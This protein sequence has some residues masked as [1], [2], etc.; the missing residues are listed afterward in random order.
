[1]IYKKIFKIIF[2]NI[3]IFLIAFTFFINQVFATATATPA[4]GGSAISADTTGGSYT[5]LNGPIISEGATGD[6]GTGT[7]ILNVPSGFV[8][9][10][11]STAPNVLVTR[12]AGSGNNNRNING[13]ASGS[14]IAVT[15]TSNTLAITITSKTSSGVRNS[16]T[17]QNVRAR[18]SAGTPLA[19]GNIIKSGTSSIS[20]VTGSTNFGT[21]TEVVGVKTQLVYTTQPSSSAETNSDFSTKPVIAVRDQ[22]GNTA[23]SDNS[24]TISLS[25]VLS[26][27][28]CG[29]AAGSGTI[30]ST[31]VSGVSVVSGIVAYTAMK[32]S[33]GESIKICA[34]SSGL[35]SAL[36]NAVSVSN[37]APV[38]SLI[39]PTSR[40]AGSGA[41]TL[42]LNGSGFVSDSSVLW[43][44][45]SRAT[46]FVSS[47][48]LTAAITAA[49]VA[50]VGT[51]SVSVSNPAPGGGVSGSQTFT[52]SVG[53]T[54]QL[55]LNNISSIIAGDRASYVVNR[56]DQ[57]GNLV[58]SGNETFYLYSSATGGLSAFYDTASA[59]NIITSITIPNG[60]SS[61][62]FWYYDQVVGTS[63]ISISDNSTAPDG[64]AGIDDATDQISI[65]AATANQFNLNDPGSITAGARAAY[66]ITRKDQFGNLVSSGN[67][68]AY[69]YSDAVGQNEKFYDSATNG[70]IITSVIIPDGSSS[71]NFWYYDELVGSPTITASDN[72]SAPDGATGIDDATD[73]ISITATLVSQFSLNDVSS[74][75]AGT[76]AA[77]TITRKDQ[78]GNLTTS[79]NT[80][81]YLYTNSTGTSAIFYDAASA[82]NAITSIQIADG[83]S[84]ANF[85]Y[86]DDSIGAWTI[87]ASDNATAPDGAIGIVDATDQ[88]A[89]NAAPIVATRF[90]IVVQSSATAG[91]TV[92]VTIRAEDSSGN[93]DTSYSG[94]VTLVTSG[95]ATLGGLVSVVNGI[96][97]VNITDTIAE[98]VNLSLSDTQGT[99]LNISSTAQIIFSPGSIAQFNLNDPGSITAGT[100]AAYTITR[101][102]QFGNLV[103]SGN[104]TAYL[105]TNATGGLS[106]FYDAETN[107]NIISSISIASGTSSGNF[108]YFE[109]AAG[110]WNIT[111]SDN[112]TAPDGNTGISDSVDQIIISSGAT[113]QF[114][115]NN[116]GDM[117][118]GTRLGYVVSRKDEF[119]NLTT[120]GSQIVHIYSTDNS[121]STA[122]YNAA[123]GGSPIS[124]IT[125]SSGNSS[126]N[127]WYYDDSVNTWT[128]TASDNV[129][130]P[131]GNV[132]IDDAS[133][134][135]SV[136]A[137]PIVATRFAIA[138]VSDTQVGQSAAVAI[139]AED[140]SG[141][142]D[143]TFNGAVTLILTGSATGGGLVTIASGIG[144][145][146][147]TDSTAETITLTLSDS[148]STGLDVSSTRILVFTVAA[149]SPAPVVSPV[150]TGGGGGGF[151]APLSAT[152]NFSGKT[153]P[154]AQITLLTISDGNIPISQREVASRNGN[155]NISF[156][157][158]AFG[159]RQF[160]LIATDPNQRISQSKTYALTITPSLIEQNI[161]LPPTIGFLRRVATKGGFIAITG[162]GVPNREIEVE[163]D[164]SLLSERVMA[165][166]DGSWSLLLNTL[167]LSLGEHRVRAHQKISGETFTEFS[168]ENSFSVISSVVSSSDLNDDGRISAS[169]V[170]IFISR[171]L[172]PDSKTRLQLDFNRD[173]KVDAQDLSIFVRSLSF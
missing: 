35:T 10:T 151:A 20:G 34:S 37:P 91:D 23:T 140:N 71:A 39:S 2:V 132:G 114:A 142:V 124:Q 154:G 139:R 145:A 83:N 125:I 21:L 59:G 48:Q 66:T 50:S 45:F 13:L 173:G 84:S 117:T 156:K 133:D 165:G 166:N 112:A 135:V 115:L 28:S 87:T 78:F 134:S 110:T 22:F 111:A 47:T 88:L 18:P 126:V 58:T 127:F 97:S 60:T 169:D 109:G 24:T 172:S 12:I 138:Q 80:I 96:G 73:Q 108:W 30:T 25:A 152:V 42:T 144:S 65:T 104:T 46:T 6:I 53:P 62:S 15:R 98:T 95:S 1:M 121:T 106:A 41:F 128:I 74:I 113:S 102:D 51:A 143:T 32:Y 8:F 36:S 5:S 103:S 105:Y 159:L 77:Y 150:A 44:G 90:T 70:N 82:G 170:S 146:N 68:T 92:A 147:I 14:T 162:Y 81:A 69:L 40:D 49:D 130:A 149:V 160:F 7:I 3:F 31:P 64:T 148:Q 100:R 75:T 99:G 55:F 76:R 56:K 163:L 33:Y 161:I 171:W 153:F 26:T 131:D 11:G 164:K 29:G 118:A 94:G 168:L 158:V 136:S 129:T 61:A 116:P 9:D 86:Y 16:L 63:T 137:A 27:Q 120:S 123:S 157:G 107:G 79:G 155:F 85:W 122:F 119:G 43:N 17:W 167:D 38:L 89:V 57:A 101:K 72:V 52:I 19:S 4:T 54:S 67:T 141:N 93:L